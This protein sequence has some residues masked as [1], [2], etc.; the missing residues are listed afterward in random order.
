MYLNIGIIEGYS[1]KED[2]RVTGS[3]LYTQTHTHTHTVG[4]DKSNDFDHFAK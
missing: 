2:E 1:E 4:T 3:D